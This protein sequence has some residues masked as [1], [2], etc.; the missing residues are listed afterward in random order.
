MRRWHEAHLASRLCAVSRCRSVWPSK[1][2][3]SAGSVPASARRRRRRRGED[4]AQDPVAALDRAGAQR[5]RRRGQHRAEAQRAAAVER[6]RAVDLLDGVGRRQLL[7][8]AVELRQRLVQER[9]VGVE[10]LLHRPPLAD[11][12]LEGRDRFLV[13]RRLHVVGELGE[14]R[15]V[16]A[17]ILVE[18]VE[19]EPLAEELGGQAARLRVGGHPRDL[20]RQLL[21]IAQLAG[22]GG[23]A[24]LVVRN[25]RP[26]EE[27]H[28]AG[29]LPVV[30]RRSRCR[31]APISTR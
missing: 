21:R 1:L 30:E 29:H 8:D 16:D 2:L 22:R 18:V 5:R 14:A 9:V 23:A 11:Q 26:Q 7:V 27:A 31:A 13:H 19:A 12:V 6:R 28:A 17:A 15:G 10:D 20:R 24:Q 4:A 25:R 3:S